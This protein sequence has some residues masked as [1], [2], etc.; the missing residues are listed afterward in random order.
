MSDVNIVI[1]NVARNY[2]DR[3]QIDNN[4]RNEL[5]L[6][7]RD[8]IRMLTVSAISDNNIHS[9]IVPF[10]GRL[11]VQF[12]KGIKEWDLRKSITRHFQLSVPN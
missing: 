9:H 6:F 1:W 7:R 11:C 4:K 5:K 12:L 3:Y 10:L 2:H 8:F